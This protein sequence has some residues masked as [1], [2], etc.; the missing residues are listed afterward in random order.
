MSWFML[1]EWGFSMLSKL[2]GINLCSD[3]KLNKSDI[4]VLKGQKVQK[5]TKY[6]VIINYIMA[7][8]TRVCTGVL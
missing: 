7:K 5:K 2:E 4:G 3:K 8:S 1:L 6:I